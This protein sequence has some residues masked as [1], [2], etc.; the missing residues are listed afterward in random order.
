MLTTAPDG[1][2]I[3]TNNT[4]QYKITHNQG[5]CPYGKSSRLVCRYNS[6]NSGE[7]QVCK[8]TRTEEPF[9]RRD[10]AT[11]GSTIV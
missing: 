6:V 9:A 2:V 3:C 10:E 5:N 1:N 8:Y 11:M 4:K 7:C